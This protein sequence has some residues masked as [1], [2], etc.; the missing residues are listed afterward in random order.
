MYQKTSQ[1]P[2]V[3]LRM[4]TS[5]QECIVMDLKLHKH[6]ILL[7]LIDDATRLSVLSFVKSKGP[8]AILKA[9]FR[10]RIKIFGAPEKFL[11]DNGREFANLK[12]I[13]MTWQNLLTLQSK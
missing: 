10:S 1:R 8:E 7:H 11:R 5:F 4:A 6:R 9:I 13:D 2:V 12:F 3:G